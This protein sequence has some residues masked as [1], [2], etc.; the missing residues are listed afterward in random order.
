[1]K[2]L[3]VD[4]AD[5]DPTKLTAPAHPFALGL[6]CVDPRTTLRE[7]P[8]ALVEIARAAN[9]KLHPTGLWLGPGGPLD[10]LPYAAAERKLETLPA[11][12]RAL[13]DGSGGRR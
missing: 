6:G 3:G 10:L 4:L 7:D 13:A 5:T 1:V 2:V 9:E 12:R 11:A 8:V